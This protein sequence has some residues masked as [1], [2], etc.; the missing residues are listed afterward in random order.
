MS[1]ELSIG[2]VVWVVPPWKEVCSCVGQAHHQWDWAENGGS[3]S[4]RYWTLRRVTTSATV[5]AV[6]VFVDVA[7]DHVGDRGWTYSS[8]VYILCLMK[9]IFTRLD[10][11]C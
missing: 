4:S 11:D 1:V 6:K 5:V 3:Y 7:V 2:C 8:C 9:L 10:S